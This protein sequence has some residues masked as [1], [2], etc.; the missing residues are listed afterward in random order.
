MSDRYELGRRRLLQATGAG[1]LGATALSGVGA[2][3]GTAAST[4][5]EE[6]PDP[7]DYEAIL[8]ELD[9]DGS[10]DA[11]YVITDVVELQA[12]AGDL[13]AI[14]ELGNDIDASATANWNDGAGFDPIFDETP[15]D[16]ELEE[17]DE[18]ETPDDEFE[19]PDEDDVEEP[20]TGEFSGV[21][22]GEGH[23]IA[24]LWIDRPDEVGVGLFLANAGVVFELAVTDAT[25]NGGAGGVLVGANNG[26]VGRVTVDGEVTGDDLVGG[27]AGTNSGQIVDCEATV[28]VVAAD[29]VGGAVGS[30]V[31]VLSE[32]TAAGDVTGGHS[33]GGLTGRNVGEIDQCLAEGNVDGE[34][35]V[36]GLVGQ[37]NRRLTGSIARGDVDGGVAVGGAV[38][39]SFEEVLG[40]TAEGDVTGEEPV[41]GLVGENYGEV[42]VCNALA[43]VAGEARVGGLVGWNANSGIVADAYA[44]GAVDGDEAVGALVGHLGEEFMADGESVE[45][46]RAYWSVDET[47]ADAVGVEEAGDGEVT[48]EELD[49]LAGEAFVGEDAAEQLPAFDFEQQWRAVPDDVPGPRAQTP[50]VFE[51]VDV[52][53]TELE[54]TQDDLLELTAEI[55]NTGEW[56]GTQTVRFS[57]EDGPF[58]TTDLT[59]DA[60]EV[61]E[62][63]FDELAAD[64]I[65]VGNHTFA[66]ETFDD[67]VQGTIAVE[68][69]SGDD[70]DDSDD[71]GV[72]NG[73]DDASDDA[74]T[75]VDA[76][77]DGPG[78]GVPAAIA[79]VGGAYLLARHLERDGAGE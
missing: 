39:E 41:G 42:R 64:V 48:A 46:S 62:V 14:Y 49:G 35:R 34:F 71:A 72:E 45:L 60:G 11:P 36:G 58:A 52:S 50:A 37:N 29:G 23:E 73:A 54:V 24:G 7:D 12:I 55:E 28:D 22:L 44:I 74:D 61:D 67:A 75:G 40:V 59:L 9:G 63:H 17:P 25:V 47:D 19:E 4:D 21:L 20:E 57:I 68:S 65:P 79:G 2:S 70:S 1:L 78:F 3:T 13:S 27:I 51:I 69:G 31:G 16:D 33:I 15:D 76:D 18:D 56:D 38:G 10:E 66:V 5:V 77:D 43:D 32:V 8:E 30:N 26:N 6:A 53:P